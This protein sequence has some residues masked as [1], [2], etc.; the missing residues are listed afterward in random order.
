MIY[1]DTLRF[2]NIN[3]KSM[4]FPLGITDWNYYSFLRSYLM[5]R[6]FFLT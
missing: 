6:L 3:Y 4:G 1:I 5:N 2:K